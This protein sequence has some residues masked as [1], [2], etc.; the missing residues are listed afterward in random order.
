MDYR[1]YRI[2]KIGFILPSY[3]VYEN[4]EILYKVERKGIFFKKEFIVTNYHGQR[5]L[6]VSTTSLLMGLEMEICD[7]NE[8]VIANVEPKTK[9]FA[10]QLFAETKDGRLVINGNFKRNDYTIIRDDIEVAKISRKKGSSSFHIGIAAQ[11]DLNQ[12]IIIGIV[13]SIL[14]HIS[15][16]KGN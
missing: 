12:K 5:A 2:S 14:I 6:R 16:Q 1:T 10:Q 8:N 9:L 3:L 4:E 13:L 7:E 15:T 11:A